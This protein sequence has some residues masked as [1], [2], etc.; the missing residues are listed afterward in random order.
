MQEISRR[1]RQ[2]ANAIRAELVSIALRD[3]SDP[4]LERVGMITFSEVVLSTDHK[5][6]T[7]YVSFMG[8]EEKSQE[9]QDAMKALQ[10]AAGF[11]HRLLLKRIAMKSHPK[12]YFKFDP[13]FDRAAVV[14]GALQEAAEKERTAAAEAKES[15]DE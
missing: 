12:L 4:R 1:T 5:N 10:S 3:I 14:Q 8:K 13:M 7:V 11:I 6:A 15:E 9:V 2:V